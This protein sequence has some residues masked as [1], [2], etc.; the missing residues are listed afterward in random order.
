MRPIATLAALSL[1]ACASDGPT[2]QTN[3]MAK[4][5][6]EVMVLASWHMRTSN[7]N[8]VD[9]PGPDVLTDDRQAELE[10][11]ADALEDFAPT[12]V[13]VENEAPEP[14]FALGTY[15]DFGP[16]MLANNPSESVQIGLRLA[17]RLGHD[18]VYGIDEQTSEGEPAY[19]PAG[20]MIAH[21][22]ATGQRETFDAT[23]ATIEK[24]LT[25][26]MDRFGEMSLAEAL[27][28]TNEGFSSSPDLYYNFLYTDRGEAQPAAELYAYYMM[29]N[30]KI[31]A[32]LL[33]VAEPGDRVLVVY[34]AGHKHFLEHLAEHTPGVAVVDPVPYLR[35]TGR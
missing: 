16:E 9:V 3:T 28:E 23:M 27:I 19:F 29:R 32:K 15:E 17:D 20:R 31:F 7:T 26:Q 1:V 25:E 10:H 12:V 13:A 8:M 35:R 34:G 11:I 4:E 14:S 33:D 6:I 2:P 5:P 18:A 24:T 30:A 22:E 21:L